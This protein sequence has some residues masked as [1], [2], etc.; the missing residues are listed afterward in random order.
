MTVVSNIDEVGVNLPQ[1]DKTVSKSFFKNRLFCFVCSASIVLAITGI[2]KNYDAEVSFFYSTVHFFNQKL[3][4]LGHHLDG[5]SKKNWEYFYSAS[6]TIMIYE[7]CQWCKNGI[8][9]LEKIATFSLLFVTIISLFNVLGGAHFHD[10][11]IMTLAI[12][13]MLGVGSVFILILNFT[14]MHENGE[15]AGMFCTI[16]FV[17]LP[18]AFMLLSAWAKSGGLAS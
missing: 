18:F 9:L 12:I 13:L 2:I 6:F 8:S 15:I 4:I 5:I 1:N 7:I 16:F 11:L 14:I 10:I 17:F 3:I